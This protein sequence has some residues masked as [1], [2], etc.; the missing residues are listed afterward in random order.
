ATVVGTPPAWRA[1][2]PD[3]V[4]I[5]MHELAPLVERQV[6]TV[7]EYA[8]PLQYALAAQDHAAPLLFVIAGTGA[9]AA[10]ANCRMLMR[11]LYATGYSVVCLPSPTSANFMVGAASWPVPGYMPADVAALYALMQ[12]VRRDLADELD[13]T[14]YALAGYSLGETQAAFLARYDE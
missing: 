3:D 1:E 11:A 10:S 4:P 14:G 8:T 6:P 12:A 13:I 7:L 5:D 2:L 9:T